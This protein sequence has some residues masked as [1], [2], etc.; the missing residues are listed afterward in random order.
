MLRDIK[1]GPGGQLQG[2]AIKQKL[3]DMIMKKIPRGKTLSQLMGMK[4]K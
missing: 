2:A 4:D 1:K 3:Y